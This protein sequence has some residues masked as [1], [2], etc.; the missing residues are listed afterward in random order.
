MDIFVQ[1]YVYIFVQHLRGS[2]AL[3][4]GG[5]GVLPFVNIKLALARSASR[6]SICT[7]VLVKQVKGVPGG[8]CSFGHRSAPPPLDDLIYD[9]YHA[10]IYIIIIHIYVYYNIYP[11]THTHLLFFLSRSAAALLD[12]LRGRKALM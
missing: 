9:T 5:G 6:V 4:R 2:H 1:T 3:R 8:P 7:F 10:H 11:P 12:D